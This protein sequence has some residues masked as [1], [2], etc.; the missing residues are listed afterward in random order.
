MLNNEDTD[1]LDGTKS[2]MPSFLD[3]LP[4]VPG[5]SSPE[6]YSK[7]FAQL[8]MELKEH[9]SLSDDFETSSQKSL[10]DFISKSI[11]PPSS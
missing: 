4:N 7:A 8:A 6:D 3:P 1:T 5:T 10:Y 9:K 2:W 11:S